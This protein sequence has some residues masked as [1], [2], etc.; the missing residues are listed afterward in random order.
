MRIIFLI[1][2]LVVTNYMYGQNTFPTSG[3]AGIGTTSPTTKL[4][5]AGSGAIITATDNASVQS[6]SGF[7]NSKMFQLINTQTNAVP[8]VV[9]LNATQNST[10]PQFI[11]SNS[12]SGEW[13]HNSLG[14]AVHGTSFSYAGVNDYYLN[15]AVSAAVLGDGWIIFGRSCAS[16]PSGKIINPKNNLSTSHKIFFMKSIL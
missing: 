9:H 3:N 1:V 16:A 7:G 14:F 11:L 6:I 5:V 8:S 13:A 4:T 2:S 12:G 15:D 10:R